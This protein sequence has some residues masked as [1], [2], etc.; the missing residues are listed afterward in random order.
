MPRVGLEPTHL[1]AGDF[2][3]P[4]STNFATWAGEKE[5]YYKRFFDFVNGMCFFFFIFLFT[6]CFLNRFIFG[7]V[8]NKMFRQLVLAF[9]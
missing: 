7:V 3:S 6:L 4:A 8:G 9:F 1:S 5:R 2:E